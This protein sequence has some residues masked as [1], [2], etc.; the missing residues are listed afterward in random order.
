MARTT[1]RFHSGN[2]ITVTMYSQFC[3]SFVFL[4]IIWSKNVICKRMTLYIGFIGFTL[5]RSH[6]ANRLLL[7]CIHLAK[8]IGEMK[9]WF[10]IEF[11]LFH[12][13]LVPFNVKK[14]IKKSKLKKIELKKIPAPVFFHKSLISFK[15]LEFEFWSS[16]C[17]AT[18]YS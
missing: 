5:I 2:P 14:R 10:V 7:K 15:S 16:S 3:F 8:W 11:S 13:A 18:T 17:F 4:P 9:N 12:Y 6:F 1:I